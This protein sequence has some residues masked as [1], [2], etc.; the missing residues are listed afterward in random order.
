MLIKDLVIAI[1]K[2]EGSKVKRAI[3]GA[4]PGSG[5]WY[6]TGEHSRNV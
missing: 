1:Q 5:Y 2:G 3:V 6:L 4:A